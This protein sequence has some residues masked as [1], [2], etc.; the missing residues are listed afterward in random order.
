MLNPG[1]PQPQ[2]ALPRCLQDRST[3]HH[4]HLTREASRGSGRGQRK[5]SRHGKD[6]TLI[7]STPSHQVHPLP[8]DPSSEPAEEPQRLVVSPTP[9]GPVAGRE[10]GQQGTQRVH[11]SKLPVKVEPLLP[12]P[13]GP[14]GLTSG[15]RAQPKGLP[16][17]GGD[18]W[19]WPSAQPGG[20]DAAKPLWQR[21]HLP[22]GL[23]AEG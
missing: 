9:P 23:C 13:A 17:P 14:G 11:P 6:P 16:M 8:W 12:S 4:S 19:S 3:T 2:V 20:V 21:L 7:L 1:N 10:A 18:C 15:A 5:G 22:G